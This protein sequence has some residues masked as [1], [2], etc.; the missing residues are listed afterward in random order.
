MDRTRA[1]TRVL[2]ALLGLTSVLPLLAWVNGLG[3]FRAWFLAVTVPGI[4]A[5]VVL[6]TRRGAPAGTRRIIT[7]GVLGGVLGVLG[8]DL[9]RAPFQF[10][11]GYN[12][13]APIESYGV[14]LTGSSLSSGWTNLAGWAWHL[15]NGIGF[16]IAYVAVAE[17]RR[18]WW[19]VPWALTLEST[20]VFTSYADYYG[21]S[22]KTNVILIAYAAHVPFGL[23]IGWAGQHSDEIYDGLRGMTRRP[24]AVLLGG[25]GALLFVW[26]QPLDSHRLDDTPA[27]AEAAVMDGRLNPEYL[28]LAEGGCATVANLDDVAYEVDEADGSPTLAARDLVEACFADARSGVHRLRIDDRPFHGGFVIVDPQM[29]NGEAHPLRKGAAQ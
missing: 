1:S 2:I 13:F 29:S 21:L 5:L 27:G 7:V 15:S 28:R 9:I 10:G 23:A 25:I 14:L 18:W 4:V 8:Y 19:G 16:A 26:H 20:A 3:S 24:N 17:R 11:A 22:G 6:V 12:L